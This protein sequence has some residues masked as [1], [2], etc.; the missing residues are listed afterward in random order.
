MHL[1]ESI[2]FQMSFLLFVGLCGYLIASILKQPSVVGQILAGVLIGPSFLGLVTYTDFVANLAHL[3][4]IVLLFV[5]G[6]EFKLKDLTSWRSFNIALAGIIVP[7]ISGFYCAKLFHFETSTSI[8]I[9][10]A[11]TATSIA[12][13][14]N[15]LYEMGQLKSD[16]AKVIIG[17]AVIDDILALGVLAVTTQVLADDIKPIL[18]IS[19]VVKTIGFLTMAI[20]IGFFFLSKMLLYIDRTRVAEKFPDFLFVLT[21]LVAFGYALLAEAFGLSAIIGAFIAGVSL[22]GIGVTSSKS[23]K[24]G[25]EYLRIIFATIFFISLGV[26][27]DFSQ[28]TQGT[29]LFIAI[30]SIVAIL[31]KLV[32]CGLVAR[33]Y[34]L[35]W[36]NSATIGFG[37]SPRG[38]VAMLIALLGLNAKIID[39][40]IYITIVSMSVITTMVTPLVLRYFLKHTLVHRV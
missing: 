37:M 18:L 36:A 35:S 11:L 24:E 5:I 34:K 25:A 19:I 12:I 8:F 17:A 1:L 20:L 3:G 30:I 29:V 28:V 33:Q 14:A 13:T 2:E 10:T 9:G 38:E 4:A 15:V 22:E 39:Q 26:I 16:I 31:S 21:M 32:G 23:F 7:W 40:N 6:L 27:A